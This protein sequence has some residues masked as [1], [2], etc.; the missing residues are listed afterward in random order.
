MKNKFAI[1][2]SDIELNV[3]TD[4]TQEEVEALA[5]EVTE[6]LDT[7]LKSSRY[8]SK[9]DAALLLLLETLDENKKLEASAQEMK[10]KL[11]TMT[12]DL[13]I[14]KIENEKLSGKGGEQ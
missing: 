1:T 3:S 8:Y 11:E 12:L 5:A 7:V 2:V 4:Y 9:L 14:Q 6:R 10:K 13:E